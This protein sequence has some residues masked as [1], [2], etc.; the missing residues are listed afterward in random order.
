M[1]AVGQSLAFKKADLFIENGGVAARAKIVAYD[2]AKPHAVIGYAC[3]NP[4]PRVRQPP[5]LDISLNKLSR[6]RPQQMLPRQ[7]RFGNGQR[8]A[9]LQLITKAISPAGL[10]KRRACPNTAGQ[11][12][13]KQ[14]AVQ[15]NIHAAV[16]R[17][18]CHFLQ[19][20]APEVADIG[21]NSVKIGG[22]ILLDQR[23]RL[24]KICA[25]PQKAHR[26]HALSRPQHDAL[27]ERAAGV[28]TGTKGF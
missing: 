19:H 8:H 27:P 11:C 13:I 3:T 21:Q 14:P 10:V 15:H 20:I 4:L 6:R 23:A 9:V 2:K 26:L 17:F 5:M 24:F 1:L 12:L 25:L 28:E 7:L 22:T 16:R 18:N